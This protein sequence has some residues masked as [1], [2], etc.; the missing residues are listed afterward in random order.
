MN[1]QHLGRR[2]LTAS[3][4][5][6]VAL[7]AQAVGN[8]VFHGQRIVDAAV[9]DSLRGGLE[10]AGL[11]LDLTARLNTY[12][13]NRLALATEARLTDLRGIEQRAI[14][15]ATQ[16]VH[17]RLA[18]ETSAS[19]QG[20]TNG[21]AVNT[22]SSAPST[23]TPTSNPAP[24]NVVSNGGSGGSTASPSAVVDNAP[25]V[26]QTAGTTT[27]TVNANPDAS[28]MPSDAVSIVTG[29]TSVRHTVTPRQIMST[30][31]NTA[32]GRAIRSAVE[33]EVTVHNFS[34]FSAV[35]R[36]ALTARRAGMRVNGF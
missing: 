21:T 20:T 33:V 30:V 18:S 24:S 31:M 7:P 2:L 34:Q 16:A 19:V 29:T 22:P 5:A 4:L 27:A 36:D 17:T 35:A 13:D 32:D 6:A 3:L 12:I 11:K 14:D 10:I 8:N 23:S 26:G 28:A 15:R 1:T 25:P 9:L